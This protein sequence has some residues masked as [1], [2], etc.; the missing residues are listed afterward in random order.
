MKCVILA[1]GSG[2]SLWPLSRRQFPKQFMKIKEGRSILQETVVRNMPFCEE[3]IIV[4]NESYKNIVNGQMK[5]FQSLKYR[6]ILEGTPKGTGAAV[7]L[8]T[9]FANP[10]E[11]VLVV[12]S[13]N[14]IEGDGYKDS[15]IEAKEYAKE[16]Y[17]AVLGIKPESQSSTY[18]YI[19]RDKENV[20]KF[21]ARIDFDEDETE[22][23]LGYDYGEGYL[24][25]SGILVF[26]AGYD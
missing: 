18:G 14:L 16:G 24:W 25:N 6:V 12:N 20:K 8:G 13:D 9:M 22:G 19:L 7:L 4:T 11:L 17:L 2:D 15:I 21:I 5:A 23:L 10:S 3:F 26:R 1:G